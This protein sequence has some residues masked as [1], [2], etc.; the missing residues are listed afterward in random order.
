VYF[1]IQA[2]FHQA[3]E[4]SLRQRV[5]HRMVSLKVFRE[6]SGNVRILTD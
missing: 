4:P 3:E 1:Q 2:H 6:K 5:C